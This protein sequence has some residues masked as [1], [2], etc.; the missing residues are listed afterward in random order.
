MLGELRQSSAAYLFE[1]LI[2]TA[3]TCITFNIVMTRIVLDT[4]SQKRPLKP[5]LCSVEIGNS[6][7]SNLGIEMLNQ[8]EM[9]TVLD[10][11]FFSRL[12]RTWLTSSPIAPVHQSSVRS[13]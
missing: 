5:S 8:I 6:T 10:V 12:G 13:A 9:Q 4:D 2:E 3:S 1:P 7:K 11:R